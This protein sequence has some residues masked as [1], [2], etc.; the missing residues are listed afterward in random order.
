M[1]RT[2]AEALAAATTRRLDDRQRTTGRARL[3]IER[4]ETRNLLSASAGAPS[5]MYAWHFEDGPQQRYAAANAPGGEFRGGY[6][7][8]NADA[9]DTHDSWQPIETPRRDAFG[10]REASLRAEAPATIRVTSIARAPAATTVMVIYVMRVDAPP[11][12]PLNASTRAVSEDGDGRA[13]AGIDGGLLQVGQGSDGHV[14]AAASSPLGPAAPLTGSNSVSYVAGGVGDLLQLEGVTSAVAA[15][16]DVGE[17]TTGDKSRLLQALESHD[18]VFQALAAQSASL[19][20]RGVASWSAAGDSSAVSGVGSAV[21]RDAGEAGDSTWNDSAALQTLSD[22]G[23]ERPGSWRTNLDRIAS[24]VRAGR[25]YGRRAAHETQD[26][27]DAVAADGS[28]AAPGESTADGDVAVMADEGGMVLLRTP[29]SGDRF[30]AVDAAMA[31]LDGGDV[32]GA[33]IEM[34][35][36]VGMYRSFNVGAG[37]AASEQ[38]AAPPVN[39][40]DASAGAVREGVGAQPQ[41]ST[42]AQLAAVAAGGV[43]VGAWGMKSRKG[44]ADPKVRSRSGERR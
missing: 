6:E 42:S 36:G 13:S 23:G 20:L 35:A 1:W 17:S 29:E 28:P 3:G 27:D 39:S 25:R 7:S 4:L 10:D 15:T 14:R 16:Q 33:T 37:E 26:G 2:L 12:P 43:V 38:G 24:D 8:A 9:Y 40:P 5:E 32:Q 30:D 22:S 18:A 44:D 21:Q 19:R 11:P 34:E 41:T 31:R